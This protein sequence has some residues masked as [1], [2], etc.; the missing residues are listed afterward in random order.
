MKLLQTREISKHFSYYLTID[1]ETIRHI[2]KVGNHLPPYTNFQAKKMN[3]IEKLYERYCQQNNNRFHCRRLSVA[4]NYRQDSS[5]D[6]MKFPNVNSDCISSLKVR[7]FFTNMRSPRDVKTDISKFENVEG[8]I[9][10]RKEGN[11]F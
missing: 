4:L 6:S 11:F 10:R 5:Q 1:D 3:I 8:S 9:G 7:D 2:L